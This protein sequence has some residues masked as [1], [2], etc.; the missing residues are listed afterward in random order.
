MKPII[1]RMTPPL[2]CDNT[3]LYTGISNNLMGYNKCRTYLSPMQMGLAQMRLIYYSFHRN[4]INSEFDPNVPNVIINNSAVWSTSKVITSNIIIEPTNQLTIKCDLYLSPHSKIIVKQGGRLIID[5]GRLQSL[6][7]EAWLGI[8]AWG[9]KSAHQYPDANGDYQQGYLEI[10]NN[11]VIENADFAVR[12]WHSS[13]WDEMGGIV[14][15]TNSTFRNNRKAVEF[16][17]YENFE[18]TTGEHRP[19]QSMFSNCTFETDDNYVN[20]YYFQSHVTLYKVD[21]VRFYGCDFIDSR[22]SFQSP[23]Y[24][25]AMGISSLDANYLVLPRCIDIQ[26]NSW[27][28]A[29]SNLDSTNFIGLNIAV[30]AAQSRSSYSY[31]I[32]RTNFVDNLHGI[33]NSST[34]YSSCIRSDFKVG[35]KQNAGPYYIPLGIIN[36]KSSTFTFNQNKFEPQ[37]S[38]PSG[39][40]FTA[41]I[42][43]LSLG[44]DLN[45][46]RDNEFTGLGYANIA[47]GDN[48]HNTLPSY[49]LNYL[50]N[51]NTTNTKYDFYVY[52]GEGI[53]TLQGSAS[54][55]A[56]NTFSQ[57]TTPEGSDF[58]NE[59]IWPVNYFFNPNIPLEIPLNYNNGVWPKSSND[60]ECSERFT[61]NSSIRLSVTDKISY[62]QQFEENKEEYDNIK[63]VYDNLVDGGSTSSLLLDIETSWPDETWILRAQLL[64]ESP[65]LSEQVLMAA[66]DNTAVLPHAIMFEICMAN[67]EEM[68]NERFLEFLALKQDPM[69]QYMIDDLIEGADTESYKSVL[70][71]EMVEYA[72]LWNEAY[73]NL[74]RDVVLDS[75]GIVYDTLRYYLAEKATIHG[76]YEIVDSYLAEDDYTSTMSHLNN[77]PNNYTLSSDQLVE[78]NYFYDLKNTI[79]TAAN[80]G[81]NLFQLDSLEVSDLVYVADSS[82][83]VAGMQAR[84]ILNFVYGYT[85][86][87]LPDLPEPNMKRGIATQSSNQNKVS[88]SPK[89]FITAYPNPAN[90]WVAFD[91][92]LPYPAETG[93]I[94]ITDLSGRQVVEIP[95]DGPLGR[96]VWDTKDLSPGVYIYN[97][98]VYGQT[99]DVRK[100][101]INK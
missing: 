40:D 79:I 18:P 39:L 35:T 24:F 29:G 37:S 32:D 22:A 20:P 25:R 4:F 31:V 16:M 68:R 17:T 88:T 99:I 55:A 101:V 28:C 78:Y 80:Q 11:S 96:K 95:V 62:R 92:T 74:V 2:N 30:N 10:N 97:L 46:I 67:P 61:T 87:D 60:A 53:A 71:N 81:R 52:A 34:D 45:T 75:T 63:V 73:R 57:N 14:R 66:A 48:H 65:H 94:T 83:G 59:A 42:W 15:A 89:H 70:Q 93:M 44:D 56:G 3:V 64:A 9:Y 85:Y 33:Y 54:M 49:G 38:L 5:G 58:N 100:L 23:P 84:N 90:N 76:E 91:Y 41:G 21:G 50:C 12:L 69:P 47:S 13:D 6:T 1:Y 7:S 98:V 77:I 43:N 27:V 26:T 72:T 86:F 51:E 82:V 36:N 19:N 8:E